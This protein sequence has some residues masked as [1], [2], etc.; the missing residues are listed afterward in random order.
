MLTHQF[1]LPD[2]VSLK[3]GIT[4]QWRAMRW[5]TTSRLSGKPASA[6]RVWARKRD[7]HR[8]KVHPDAP[9]VVRVTRRRP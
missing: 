3:L 2:L 6:S 9:P 5:L 8:Q 1:E 7:I 4:R